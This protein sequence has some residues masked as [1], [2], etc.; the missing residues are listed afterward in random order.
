MANSPHPVLLGPV[1]RELE[2]RGHT[3]IVTTRDHAQTRDLTLSI[4]P[5]ATVVGGESPGSPSAKARAIARRVLG[6]RRVLASMKVDAAASLGS[7]AQIVAARSLGIP[8]LTLMDYEYQ[9]ANHLSF[10]LAQRVIVPSVF[11]AERLRRYGASV[12]RVVKFD[13]FKEELYLDEVDAVPAPIEIEDGRSLVVLRPPPEGALYHQ[14][15]NSPFDLVLRRAIEREDVQVV[16]LPRMAHQRSRYSQ[17]AGV[18]APEHAIDGLA[19]LRSADVFVGAGGTM[20]REAALLG[21][22]AYTMFAGRFAAVD[23]E[24]IQR[25]LLRDMRGQDP[26]SVDWTPRDGRE[27]KQACQRR[28]ERGRELRSWLTARIEELA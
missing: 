11:P 28:H 9:P 2:A 18:Q 1:A 21:V 25:G 15:G 13:G 17:M 14:Q 16:V 23:A 19:L 5:D 20:C 8:V 4:W 22:R 3:V 12:N 10:R 6:L 24:L 26:A 27:T 7:Y